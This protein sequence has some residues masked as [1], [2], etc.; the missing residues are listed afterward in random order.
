MKV[1]ING[2]VCEAQRGR[3]V[4]EVARA[5]GF[6]IP[7]L[8]IC[9]ATPKWRVDLC[10]GGRGYAVTLGFLSPPATEG[11]VV[12]TDTERVL[13]PGV[14]SSS[15][16]VACHPLDCMTCEK[17]GDCTLQNPRMSSGNRIHE[18]GEKYDFSSRQF[19]PFT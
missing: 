3:Q 5:N 2:K 8:C 15:S 16:L 17:T 7:T 4:L 14:S 1:T 13:L 12:R 6:Y 11:L 19:Q 10:G 9:Q 18:V